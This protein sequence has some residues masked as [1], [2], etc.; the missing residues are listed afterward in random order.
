MGPGDDEV[1]LR[2]HADVRVLLRRPAA[3]DQDLAADLV[4]RG[5]KSLRQDVAVA[6]PFPVIGPDDDGGAVTGAGRGRLALHAELAGVDEELRAGDGWEET[7]L[8]GLAL[9][10]AHGGLPCA[11]P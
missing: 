3:G 6:G 2:V 8:K 10:A 5:V 4:A 7:V 9:Q 11:G 1:P